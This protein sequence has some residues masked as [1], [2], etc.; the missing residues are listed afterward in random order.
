MDYAKK[1]L[2]KELMR[3][4]KHINKQQEQVDLVCSKL[5]EL[6]RLR[7][8]SG[9]LFIEMMENGINHSNQ[10][11][12]IEEQKDEIESSYSIELLQHEKGKLSILLEKKRDIQFVIEIFL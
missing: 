12:K 6:H 2:K 3:L 5:D 8:T 7:L 4:Q 1:V 11:E 9:K 10:L